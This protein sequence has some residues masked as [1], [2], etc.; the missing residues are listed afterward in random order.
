MFVSPDMTFATR[1]DNHFGVNFKKHQSNSFMTSDPFA[2]LAL[3]KDLSPAQMEV[4]RHL[5][6]PE[7][8]AAG[9]LLFEQGASADNLYIVVVGE[10]CVRYKPEDGPSILVTKVK[11]GSVVGWSAALGNPAYTSSAFCS[12]DCYLLRISKQDLHDLCA[13]HPVTGSIILDRLASVIAE[14][15]HETHPSVVALLEGGLQ[16]HLF[17]PAVPGQAIGG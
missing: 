9:E 15:L 2:Q 5:F 6:L 1:I 8:I 3:F 16:V 11:P 17:K 12:E 4:L 13:Q 14:R 10:V 7:Q